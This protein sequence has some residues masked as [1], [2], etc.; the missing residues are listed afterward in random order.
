MISN[1]NNDSLDMYSFI[2]PEN[3]QT[4][5]ELREMKE[6]GSSMEDIREAWDKTQ[7]PVALVHM[8]WWYKFYDDHGDPVS[9]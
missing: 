7:G 9:E 3:T 4:T 2:V 8:D 5:W 1:Y 6:Q